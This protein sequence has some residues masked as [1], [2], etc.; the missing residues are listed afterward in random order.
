MQLSK[1]KL[2][3]AGLGIVETKTL[4]KVS[5]T[6][7]KQ[8][9]DFAMA[10][11]AAKVPF[12]IKKDYVIQFKTKML[13]DC[14]DLDWILELYERVNPGQIAKWDSQELEKQT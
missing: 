12:D 1:F 8:A 7:E 4:T 6:C 10:L 13:V 9:L 14:D 5:L 2:L 11:N 3:T